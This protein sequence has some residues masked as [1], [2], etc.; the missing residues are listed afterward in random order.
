MSYESVSSSLTSSGQSS[1]NPE[2]ETYISEVS[3]IEAVMDKIDN[4]NAVISGIAEYGEEPVGFSFLSNATLIPAVSKEIKKW[5]NL[6]RINNNIEQTLYSPGTPHRLIPNLWGRE[7]T[8]AKQD[9]R[10]RSKIDKVVCFILDLKGSM[11]PKLINVVISTISLTLRKYEVISKYYMILFGGTV[12]TNTPAGFPS[13]TN[14]I[15]RALAHGT[16]S[17]LDTAFKKLKMQMDEL[18]FKVQAICII[19]DFKLLG[20]SGKIPDD[21]KFAV[22]YL[23]FQITPKRDRSYL[24]GWLQANTD[25]DIFA[26]SVYHDHLFIIKPMIEKKKRLT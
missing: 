17:C 13:L 5:L 22:P 12:I 4:Q 18:K 24:E 11:D 23:A 16:D 3:D 6:F 25:H 7:L 19:S 15:K 10:R 9:T 14:D 26:L 2:D 20:G 21:P 8:Y 1:S